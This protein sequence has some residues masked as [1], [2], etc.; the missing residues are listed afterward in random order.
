MASQYSGSTL[1]HCQ[2]RNE[3]EK[4]YYSEEHQSISW[5]V[6]SLIQPRSIEQI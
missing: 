3:I 1:E 6:D 4:H 2:I 5:E